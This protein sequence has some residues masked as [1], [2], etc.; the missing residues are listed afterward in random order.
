[1]KFPVFEAR[2]NYYC[3][4]KEYTQVENFKLGLKCNLLVTLKYL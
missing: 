1:M 3:S 2:F 4:R